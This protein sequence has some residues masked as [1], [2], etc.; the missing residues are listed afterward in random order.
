MFDLFKSEIIDSL[1]APF[2]MSCI[3]KYNR[4]KLL[5]IIYQ[6]TDEFLSD[7]SILRFAAKCGYLE[8]VRYLTEMGASCTSDAMD[9]AALHG[10]IEIVKFLHLNR[11]EGCKRALHYAASNGQFEVV[12]YLVENGLGMNY[13]HLS[14]AKTRSDQVRR[15][16]LSIK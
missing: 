3:F 7:A 5:K 6:E 10:N 1:K 11:S 4:L 2:V 16:L 12:K 13:L 14:I 9:S 15:Y 8:I